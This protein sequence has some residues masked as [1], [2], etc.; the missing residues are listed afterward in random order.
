M[1]IK[2]IL[3]PVLSLGGLGLL[4]GLL[5]GFANDKFKVEV[6]ERIPKV[7]E[8]LPGANCG[9]CGFAGCDAYA[10]AV[11][12]G[13]AKPNLCNPG[14]SS[15]ASNISEILG[16]SVE[17]GDLVV[18]YVHCNG[19]CNNAKTKSIYYGV[20]DCN[21]AMNT[22]GAGNKSCDFGCLGFGSCVKA[23]KFDALEIVDGVAKVNKD[24]C[25]ACGACVNACPKGIITIVPKETKVLI[26]CNSHSKGKE[27]MDACSVGCIGCG[28]CAK[29]CPKEAITMVNNLPV[30]DYSK[31]V[32]C[33]ICANKCPK[34]CIEN[35]RKPVN[36]TTP[37]AKT[38]APVAK[39]EDTPNVKSENSVEATKSTES[40]S[41]PKDE[42]K[43]DIN[44]KT[45]EAVEVKE[46]ETSNDKENNSTEVSH[47][48][49]D[50]LEK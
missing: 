34:H 2:E 32:N 33:G 42:V 24:N 7:R 26:N 39:V 38:K 27:V 4:F 20:K 30:I 5:L 49:E 23:C 11:V 45:S 46:I 14:G 37:T 43:V 31:C 16:I 35:L 15:A 47:P 10:E 41:E 28:L 21:M 18:A 3:F 29:N 9:S 1:E 40:K 12:N 22:P 48:N 8:C 6:D 17:M 44:A 13:E 25:V 36:K 50:K 19:T